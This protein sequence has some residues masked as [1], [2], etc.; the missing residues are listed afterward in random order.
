MKPPIRK[1][2]VSTMDADPSIDPERKQAALDILD[3]KPSVPPPLVSISEYA[4][5]RSVSR[6]TAWRWRKAGRIK[7]VMV[8]GLPRYKREVNPK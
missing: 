6:M 8:A 2:L 5:L 7:P 1:A 4:R 3:G